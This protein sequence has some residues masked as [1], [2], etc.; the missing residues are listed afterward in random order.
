MQRYKVIGGAIQLNRKTPFRLGET[1]TVS[2][3][4]GA[5]PEDREARLKEL[6]KGKY[7]A[8]VVEEG[9]AAPPPPPAPVAPP[10]VTPPAAE[11]KVEDPG[12]DTGGTEQ[13]RDEI[14]TELERLGI[15]YAR[16]AKT[17]D[18][19][20]LLEESKNSGG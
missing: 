15:K 19:F 9:A 16:N 12:G 13:T 14:K 4:N 17:S 18:L 3:V 10:V 11:T 7:C 1:F 5:R 8:L 2:N 6:I 20:K